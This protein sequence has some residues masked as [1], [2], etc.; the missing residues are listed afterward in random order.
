R[1]AEDWLR[2]ALRAADPATGLIPHEAGSPVPRGSSTAL[3]IRFEREIDPAVAAAQYAIFER[4]FA[5]RFAGVLPAVREYP[6]GTR[7]DEDVDSGPVVLGVSAPASVVGIAAARMVGHAAA[8]ADLRAS[9][10]VLGVPLQW[11]G[12]RSYAFG[13]LPVGEAF[14][15]WASVVRPWNVP[16][17]A[18]SSAS[19]FGPWRWV[20]IVGWGLF[21]ALC[22]FRLVVLFRA[23]RV[24]QAP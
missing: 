18:P 20:W 17:A 12:R 1:A 13:V 16:A 3:M 7:G 23:S 22:L 21:L 6:R 9:P 2:A 8:A 24:S 11:G 14:L 19:P 4:V 5:T 10:E 15:A